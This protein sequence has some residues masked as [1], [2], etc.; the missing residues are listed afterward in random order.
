MAM[1]SEKITDS[2]GDSYPQFLKQA[3]HHWQERAVREEITGVG[4]VPI[5]FAKLPVENARGFVIVATGRAE[6][7]L[8]YQDVAFELNNAGY[9]V[10]IFDHRGQGF[11]GR[12]LSDPRKGHVETFD[13]YVS[14][15]KTL[16]DEH[17]EIEEGKP[18]AI[19]AH[20]MGGTV[21]ALYSQVYPDDIDGL[22]LSSPM[23]ALPTGVFGRFLINTLSRVE[24]A[25]QAIFDTESHYVPGIGQYT[26]V[27]FEDNSLTHSRE[28]FENIG[29]IAREYPL[30]RLGDPTMHWVRMAYAAMDKIFAHADRIRKPTLILQAGDDSIID[31]DGQ[32]RFCQAIGTHC[33]GG[34]PFTIVDGRHELLNES[35]EYRDQA[36]QKIFDFLDTL[37]QQ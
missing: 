13:D 7:L 6:N 20:S 12:L 29:R 35:D 16:F 31:N 32:D 2:L 37:Q 11:S 10:L 21:S 26:N 33:V 8:K 25:L 34:K 17:V 9:S 4:N 27:A 3:Q 19:L 18:V 22:I 36:M 28:R 14:D 23:L 30:A 1:P 24:R 15:L 5:A